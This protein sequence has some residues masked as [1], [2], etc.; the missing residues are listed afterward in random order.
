[1]ATFYNLNFMFF[2]DQH[3]REVRVIKRFD[4]SLS[5][6]LK[7]NIQFDHTYYTCHRSDQ[8]HICHIHFL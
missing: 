1:M 4:G 3:Q 2:T 5:S 7:L 6:T 8:R